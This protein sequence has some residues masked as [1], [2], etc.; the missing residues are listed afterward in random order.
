MKFNFAGMVGRSV[1]P[2]SG[3]SD[4]SFSIRDGREKTYLNVAV[5]AM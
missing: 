4:E 1:E 5:K 3:T 2:Q